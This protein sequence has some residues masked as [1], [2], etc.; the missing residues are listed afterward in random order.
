MKTISI[1]GKEVEVYGSIKELPIAISKRFHHYL[2]QDVG[3]GTS[4]ESIDDHLNRLRIFQDSDKKAEATE[5]LS[6]LRYSLFS[7]L[8]EIDF[9]SLS[10][11]CLIHAV[12]GKVVSDHTPEGLSKLIEELN[13]TGLEVE[14]HLQEVKKNL[15]PNVATTSQSSFPTT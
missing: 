8:S 2:L 5:E 13:P 3:I 1:N 7:M 9:R 14:E 6:N 10:F 15:I 12:D 11:A 4:I